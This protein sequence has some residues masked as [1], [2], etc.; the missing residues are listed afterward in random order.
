LRGAQKKKGGEDRFAAC[1]RKGKM[2]GWQKKN[3]KKWGGEKRISFEGGHGE[4]ERNAKRRWKHFNK[5]QQKEEKIFVQGE[6]FSSRGRRSKGEKQTFDK[7]E[8][9][10]AI[11]RGKACQNSREEGKR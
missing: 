3:R 2:R 11:R 6:G 5:A 9:K 4:G 7:E 1:G 10:K 8:K